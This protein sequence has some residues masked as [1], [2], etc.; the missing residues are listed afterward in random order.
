MRVRLLRSLRSPAR[1]SARLPTELYRVRRVRDVSGEAGCNVKKPL[2]TYREQDDEVTSRATGL[3]RDGNPVGH[4]AP[5]G[6][7]GGN[8][9]PT[10][11]QRPTGT[12]DAP[13]LTSKVV[14][15]VTLASHAMGC[16]TSDTRYGYFIFQGQ[17]PEEG[18]I[19]SPVFPTQQG[20]D[21]WAKMHGWTHTGQ[22]PYGYYVKY[23]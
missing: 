9:P 22:L 21:R 12:L 1:A 19:L 2:K 6:G 23:S 15:S 3:K 20:L 7:S 11:D 18:L 5:Q 13:K 10:K 8:T 14:G 4:E 17:K 16:Y